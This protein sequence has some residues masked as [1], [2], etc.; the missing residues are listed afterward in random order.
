[1]LLFALRWAVEPPRETPLEVI[2]PTGL[3]GRLRHLSAALGDWMLEPGFPLRVRELRP[4]DDH[5]LDEQVRLECCKT[6]HTDESLAYALSDQTARLV[7]TGDTGP[8]EELATWAEGCDLLLAECSLPDERAIAIHLTPAQAG[9]L[10]RKAKARRLVLT[11]FYPPVEEVDPAA[12]AAKVF[13]GEVT[14]AEDGDRFAVG[15]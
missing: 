2:G 13:G 9:D 1:M 8:S 7:Y 4:G 5:A 6:R 10:A 12:I 14:A 15:D 11:H 3:G